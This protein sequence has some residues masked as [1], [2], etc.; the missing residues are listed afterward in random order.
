MTPLRIT[1]IVPTKDEVEILPFF[2]RH[3]DP[4]VDRYLVYDN[5]ST[6]PT[7]FEM[8]KKNPKVI[9][10]TFSTGGKNDSWI[11]SHLC[12]TAHKEFPADPEVSEWIIG[13]DTDEFLWHPRG[14]RTY[15]AECDSKG[16]TV[17]KVAGYDM[18]SESFP[19][20]DG[21]TP[22]TDLVRGGLPS[23]Q[24]CKSA[25]F[26]SSMDMVYGVGNH[27]H[28]TTHNGV[29][30]SETEVKLLHYVWLSFEW[31]FNR[32]VHRAKNL[33]EKNIKNRWS[34]PLHK[35]N[36]AEYRKNFGR[37]LAQKVEVIDG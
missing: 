23:P 31:R 1:L 7:V 20:D 11:K 15:L 21:K 14:L 22:I 13:L 16:V 26:H 2:F 29:V 12:C 5:E 36:E 10:R 28:D 9:L 18:F 24:Y 4:I 37:C 30:S 32:M 17:P 25:I 27:P 19:A 35:L 8:Y 3:Y 34:T 6:N 33:S